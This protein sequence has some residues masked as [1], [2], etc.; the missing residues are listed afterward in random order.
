MQER[1]QDH[2]LPE[3]SKPKQNIR[4]NGMEITQASW[5]SETREEEAV[6]RPRCLQI[7]AKCSATP[8][9]NAPKL[10]PR[11]GEALER[12][13]AGKRKAEGPGHRSSPEGSASWSQGQHPLPASSEATQPPCECRGGSWQRAIL[14][15]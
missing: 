5:N 11:H 3:I 7:N 10:R 6:S 9:T 4:T 14:R 12:R 2:R 15:D 8:K 13:T 1:E